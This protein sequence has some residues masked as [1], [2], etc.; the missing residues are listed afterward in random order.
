MSLDQSRFYG[1]IDIQRI[2]IMH[3]TAI[4]ESKWWNIAPSHDEVQH[5]ETPSTH[6]HT[7]PHLPPPT[8]NH[9]TPNIMAEIQVTY[10]E[11]TGF[12]LALIDY[13]KYHTNNPAILSWLLVMVNPFKP[14]LGSLLLLSPWIHWLNWENP[15][16]LWF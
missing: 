16:R 3:F 10:N 9:T 2:L 1:T 15:H 7:A 13:Y 12:L 6:P 8:P 5:N 4:Y 11:S 14:F